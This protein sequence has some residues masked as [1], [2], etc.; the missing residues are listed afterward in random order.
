[1]KNILTL[2][3]LIIKKLNIIK[4]LNVNVSLVVKKT[5]FINFDN[6]FIINVKNNSSNKRDAFR[7]I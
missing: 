2:I 6:Q 5:I 3:F 1:M 4:C 7:K